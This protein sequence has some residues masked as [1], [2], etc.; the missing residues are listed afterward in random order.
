[1]NNPVISSP[2]KLAPPPPDGVDLDVAKAALEQVNK[3]LEA[4]LTLKGSTETRALTLAGQCTTLVTA[5][6][7]ALLVEIY[8]DHRA[9]LLAAGLV[10]ALFLFGAILFAYY[11]ADP[12]KNVVLPGRLPDELWNDF[13]YPGMAADLF[14]ARLMMSQREAMIQNE[15]NQEN[16]AKAL[17]RAMLLVR[18][19]VPAAILAAMIAVFIP[20]IISPSG[21]SPPASSQSMPSPS[22]PALLPSPT[23]PS[24][25][26]LLPPPPSSLPAPAGRP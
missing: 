9:P 18:L 1:V 11:S 6:A 7:A 16:R 14:I 20:H 19:A 25:P 10:G 15:V 24:S 21:T 2:A 5:L 17:N 23:S 3:R 4:E 13:I 12:R 22:S 26:A 8:G